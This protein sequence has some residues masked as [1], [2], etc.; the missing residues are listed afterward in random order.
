MKKKEP[1]L[2]EKRVCIKLCD[3]KCESEI[4]EKVKIKPQVKKEV[5]PIKPVKQKKLIKKAIKKKVIVKK[6]IVKKPK[7]KP[8]PIKIPIQKEIKPKIVEA[9]KVKKFEETPKPIIKEVSEEE[10]TQE[11]IQDNI[12]KIVELLKDNLYY[13]RRARKKGISGEVIVSFTL[14]T[15]SKVSEIKVVK[16]KKEILSRAAIKTIEDLSGKFP[17]PKEELNI[18]LPIVYSLQN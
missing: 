17:K 4:K 15:N 12:S 2:C 5:K 1:V 14:H 10:L 3:F 11:Y 16:S 8:T 13:P 7:V 6:V 9:V 18:Q